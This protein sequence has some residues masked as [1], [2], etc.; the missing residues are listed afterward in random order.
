MINNPYLIVYS[1]EN[2]TFSRRFFEKRMLPSRAALID[3]QQEEISELENFESEVDDSN[4]E[5]HDEISEANSAD[6]DETPK[7]SP[8]SNMIANREEPRKIQMLKSE[9]EI[10]YNYLPLQRSND[11]VKFQAHSKRFGE[12]DAKEI[13]NKS[14]EEGSKTFSSS[15]FKWPNKI[16]EQKSSMCRAVPIIIDFGDL[17]FADWIIE[18]KSFQSNYCAGKCSLNEVHYFRVLK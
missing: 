11:E 4:T 18:P 3:D 13:A 2:E 5:S 7:S 9:N 10:Y 6:I 1:Y 14:S 8:I 12:R 16:S 17:S 15:E